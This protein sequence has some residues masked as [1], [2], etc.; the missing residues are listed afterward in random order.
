MGYAI[1]AGVLAV[2]VWLLSLQGRALRRRVARLER[3]VGSD[4]P[5]EGLWWHIGHLRKAIFHRGA[6]DGDPSRIDE[7]EDRVGKL[8]S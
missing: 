2:G 5:G 6:G 3:I 4:A 1:I 8:E 7:L